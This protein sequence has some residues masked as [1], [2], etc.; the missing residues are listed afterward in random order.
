[1]ASSSATPETFSSEQ[2]G[3]TTVAIIGCGRTGILQAC[4]FAQAGLKVVCADVD[5]AV[6]ARLS[7][8]KL[9]FLKDEIAPIL[10]G[11]METGKLHFVNDLEQAASQAQ[12]LIIAVPVDVDD[13][14]K[15]D[16]SIIERV[17]RR[18]AAKIN[19]G[20]LIILSCA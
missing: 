4:L 18:L 15:T 16:Y 8:G 2:R 20:T 12:T 19:K 14:G 9:P 6:V 1:M 7:K 5:P 3:E 10:L 17:L 11:F 13:K